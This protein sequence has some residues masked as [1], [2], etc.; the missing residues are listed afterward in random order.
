MHAPTLSPGRVKKPLKTFDE[1]LN[2]IMMDLVSRDDVCCFSSPRKIRVLLQCW[3]HLF[4]CCN[5]ISFNPIKQFPYISCPCY[6]E[7]NIATVVC[8][9]SRHREFNTP[10]PMAITRTVF[11]EIA[12]TLACRLWRKPITSGK[13][14]SLIIKG[15]PANDIA[16]NSPSFLFKKLRWYFVFKLLT[17]PVMLQ[18]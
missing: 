1:S 9:F 18:M 3:I 4:L 13:S 17:V 11:L 16:E 2:N 15:C 10:L 14:P 7:L 12:P 8:Y 5:S 6:S